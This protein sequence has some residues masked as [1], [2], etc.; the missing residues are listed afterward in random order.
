MSFSGGHFI[1]VTPFDVTVGETPENASDNEAG[2]LGFCLM[3]SKNE[4]HRQ[5]RVKQ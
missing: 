5:K 4:S 1:H 3:G 2:E